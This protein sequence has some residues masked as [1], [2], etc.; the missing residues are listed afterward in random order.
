MNQYRVKT[1]SVNG[2]SKKIYK[3]GDIVFENNFIPGLAEK[4]C[5]L[6]FLELIGES[7]NLK[8]TTLPPPSFPIKGKIKVAIVT[9]V[10]KRPEV[11][12]LFAK[13]IRELINNSDVDIEVIVAGSEGPES[14]EMVKKHGFIYVEMPNEPLASKV[15]QPVLIAGQLNV[16]YVLCVGSDDIITPGLMKVYESYMRSGVDYIAVTDF[17]FYDLVSKKAAYWGGYTDKR[18]GHT[19]GAGRLISRRLMDK[20]NWRPWEVKDSKVL[21]NSM[22]NKLK[23]TPHTEAIFSL[24]EKNV[25]AIDIK[26]ETNMTPFQLWENTSYIP[27]R[28][29]KKHFPYLCAE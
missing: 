3:S 19:A 21:D 12:E 13:G 15:N 29:I 17:Y 8:I 6:K 24:K 10:W 20:W 9:A 2:R 5:N 4:L 16:D 22:Q 28:E 18:K 26:S 25:F 23:T 1:L 27:L 7:E 11:F 14:R